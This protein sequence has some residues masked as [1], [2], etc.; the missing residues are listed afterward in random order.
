MKDHG[1]V[2]GLDLGSR[3]IGVAVTDSGQRVATGI[4]VVNRGGDR[5]ADHRAVAA[6]VAEYEAVGVVVGLPISM[7]GET[8]PS[9][10]A[11]LEE[12]DE[13]RSRVA[14]DVDTVDERLTTL[15]ASGALRAAGR[16][17]RRQRT[18]I[19]QTAAAVLLQTWVDRRR[20]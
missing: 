14:V 2:L 16:P 11:V 10:R 4:Q 18:L 3:R 20:A 13:I 5:R 6:L 17:A 7:S 12:I 9:A 8:G 1:R 15:A 19:D